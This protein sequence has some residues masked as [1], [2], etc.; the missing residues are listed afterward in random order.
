MLPNENV[1]FR[2]RSR[3]RWF[4]NLKLHFED[5]KNLFDMSVPTLKIP[6]NKHHGGISFDVITP[7]KIK[8]EIR[9]EAQVLESNCNLRLKLSC[10]LIHH[11][12]S[13]KTM[14][15]LQLDNLT[16]DNPIH[17]I[18]RRSSCEE[19]LTPN[20]KQPGLKKYFKPV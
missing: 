6:S 5:L 12:V 16:K 8:D 7:D 3:K 14:Y 18:L 4:D 19:S 15:K 20:K 13:S 17:H 1:R 2:V 10:Y 9:S 11:P